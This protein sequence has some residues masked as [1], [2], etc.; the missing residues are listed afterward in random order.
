MKTIGNSIDIFGDSFS[1]PCCKFNSKFNASDTWLELL[2]KKYKF[3]IKNNS[4]HGTGAQWCVEEFMGLTEYSDFLLFCLPDMNRLSLDYLKND[5]FSGASMLYSI[6]DRRSL[7]FPESISKKLKNKSSRIFYDYESFY[8]TGLNRILEVLYTSFIFTK[9]NKYK[10]ILIWPSSG[11]GYPFQNYNYTLEIPDNVYIVP[12]CLNLISH[13]E[14]KNVKNDD[15]I[16]FGKDN[17]SN[18]LS[19]SNH[20]ILAKQVSNFFIKD[21]NPDPSEFLQN[22]L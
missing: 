14:K 21:I 3:T 18:H 2:E 11:I 13:Y 19:G 7:D 16:F 17:R 1:C 8:T 6:M 15:E 10:K 4:L 12:R 5:E 9:H 22:F 20:T